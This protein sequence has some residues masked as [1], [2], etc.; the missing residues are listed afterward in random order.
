MKIYIASSMRNHLI[1]SKIT[2]HLQNAGIEVF[3]PQRDT[4]V[5][6]KQIEK[7]DFSK[8]IYCSNIKAIDEADVILVVSRN[9]GTDTAWECGYAIGKNKRIYALMET[10]DDIVDMYMLYGALSD[11]IHNISYSSK[12][13]FNHSM[14]SLIDKLQQLQAK[15]IA[16]E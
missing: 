13:A 8:I 4:T 11:S 10:D 15:N 12:K 6:S 9:I 2:M 5:P 7:T 3:L 14:Q 16:K 1:N